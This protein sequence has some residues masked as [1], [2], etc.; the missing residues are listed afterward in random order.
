MG[1]QK[2]EE[3]DVC[4]GKPVGEDGK[5]D[6]KYELFMYYVTTGSCH[7]SYGS[8]FYLYVFFAI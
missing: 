2:K 5:V 1:I 3:E 8:R 7:V 6:Y 4:G